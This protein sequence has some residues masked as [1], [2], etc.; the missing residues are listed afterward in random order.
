MKY[1]RGNLEAALKQIDPDV[2]DVFKNK[3]KM[4]LPSIL[5]EMFVL[6]FV[7][8]L[9]QRKLLVS[10]NWWDMDILMKAYDDLHNGAG[11]FKFEEE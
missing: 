3:A 2:F 5:D 9:K 7:R 4:D 10:L 8:S 6:G 1:T 11:Y